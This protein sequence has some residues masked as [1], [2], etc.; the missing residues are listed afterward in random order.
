VILS[1]SDPTDTSISNNTRQHHHSNHSCY[2]LRW[3]T[4]RLTD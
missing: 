4:H 2:I 3:R 1:K